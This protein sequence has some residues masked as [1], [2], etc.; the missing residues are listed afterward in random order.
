M[1]ADPPGNISVGLLHPPERH[2]QRDLQDATMTLD[3]PLLLAVTI[4]AATVAVITD[5]DRHPPAITNLLGTAD[6]AHGLDLHLVRKPDVVHILDLQF[7]E[8]TVSAQ[9]LNRLFVKLPTAL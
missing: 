5:Q 4:A 3:T 2:H 1:A 6:G 8:K 9:S 7:F